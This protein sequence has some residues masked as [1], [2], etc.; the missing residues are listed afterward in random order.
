MGSRETSV[1]VSGQDPISAC[2]QL[3]ERNLTTTT[4]S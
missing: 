1:S 3:N 4:T 2:Q